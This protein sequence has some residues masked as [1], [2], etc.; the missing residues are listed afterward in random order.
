MMDAFESASE[1]CAEA[2]EL[3]DAYAL[4]ALDETEA[5]IVERHVAGCLSCWEELAK[6]QRTAGLLA[7]SVPIQQAPRPLEE[8]IMAQAKREVAAGAVVPLWVRL[9]L[10]RRIAVRAVTLAGV[11]ALVFSAFLQLQMSS[12]RGDKDELEQQ[13]SITSSELEQ[14]RQIVAVLSASDSRKIAMEAALRSPAESVYNW[15]RDN[16]AGFIVC[17]DFPAPAEGT[18]YQ[19]WFTTEGRAEPVATFVPQDGGCQIP[20]DMSRVDWRPMGIGIS[21]EPAGGSER[22]SS[23]WFSYASFEQPADG[24]GRSM[25]GLD[26]MVA[27][28]GP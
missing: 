12:L 25:N 2:L 4:G 26:V 20:I 9:R 24:S 21:V 15:S 18:V 7:L 8:R 13:L 16:A 3:L 11:A 6:S 14:Q 22:P 5:K 19:I 17:R 28:I 10:N 27:A 1:G 23:R